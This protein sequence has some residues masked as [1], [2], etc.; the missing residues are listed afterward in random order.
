VPYT[1][2][3]VEHAGEICWVT[4]NRPAD[5]NAIDSELMAEIEAFLAAAEQTDA[6]AAVFSGA[7]ETHFIGGADGVEMMLCDAQGARAFSERIQ[8]LFA[9]ME[10]SAMI[11]TAAINGLCFGGGF[12]FALACD[13]RLAA[14]SARIGLPEVKVGIIPGGGGTQRLPRLVGSGRAMEMILSGTLYSGRQA[15]ALGLVNRVAPA[16]RLR[17]EAEAMLA[18]ILRNPRHAIVQAKRAVNAAQ[19]S[20][21]EGLRAERDAFGRCFENDFFV[22]L[23]HR[24]LREGLLKT[25]RPLSERKEK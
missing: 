18:P 14:E 2:L 24:Q 21:A 3:K 25:T 8:T 16:D 19:Q 4:I 22:Q 9:R 1:R 12:E 5:R 20:F 7:G 11:L 17:S 23:M 6:R 10:Q 15:L 13:L